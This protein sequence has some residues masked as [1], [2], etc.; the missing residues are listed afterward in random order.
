MASA[1]K[2]IW[3]VLC[4]CC[5][6]FAVWLRP[7]ALLHGTDLIRA[8]NTAPAN[9]PDVVLIV[10]DDLNDWIGVMNGHP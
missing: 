10:V 4:F 3:R 7:M 9:Q 6:V 5:A 2:I 1:W 8:A